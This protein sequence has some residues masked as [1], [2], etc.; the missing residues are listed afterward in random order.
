MRGRNI[1]VAEIFNRKSSV[2]QDRKVVKLIVNAAKFAII[3]SYILVESVSQ[4]NYPKFQ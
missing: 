3:N 1:Y 2:R 4:L